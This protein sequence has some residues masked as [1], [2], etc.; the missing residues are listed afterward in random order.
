MHIPSYSVFEVNE[1]I[2]SIFGVNSIAI[3]VVTL[4]Y[5]TEGSFPA[6]LVFRASD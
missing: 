1:S 2:H 5:L 4:F 6:D 3:I